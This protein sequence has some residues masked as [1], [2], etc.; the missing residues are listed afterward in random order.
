MSIVGVPV[1]VSIASSRAQARVVLSLCGTHPA[2]AVKISE[3]DC[4]ATVCTRLSPVSMSE[5]EPRW[6]PFGGV[7][8][9]RIAGVN[10]SVILTLFGGVPTD[11]TTWAT[12]D[13][14]SSSPAYHCFVVEVIDCAGT[15][16]FE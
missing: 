13:V 15:T 7:D 3:F 10:G 14:P 6:T 2:A 4:H 8:S 16:S 12:V 5:P 11:L 1:V 9:L